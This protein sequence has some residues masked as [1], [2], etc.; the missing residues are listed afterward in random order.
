[1]EATNGVEI[2]GA[3]VTFALDAA[4]F[5]AQGLYDKATEMDGSIADTNGAVQANV[6][7][8]AEARANTEALFLNV[9]APRPLTCTQSAQP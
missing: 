8:V 7:A 3:D 2:T 5:S 9:S 1:M 4:T 6:E